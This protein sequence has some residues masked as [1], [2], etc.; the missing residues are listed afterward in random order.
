MISHFTL[1]TLW[2]YSNGKY[3]LSS[4]IA[5]IFSISLNIKHNIN[6]INI[7]TSRWKYYKA[8]WIQFQVLI[9][10]GINRLKTADK[11][12]VLYNVYIIIM[13]YIMYYNMYYIN[14][15]NTLVEKLFGIII[16]AT[17]ETMPRTRN[18]RQKIAKQLHIK[19]VKSC[20]KC[21]HML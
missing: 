21:I 13:Y 3:P 8:D 7:N 12:N 17:T 2:T 14:L 1:L 6:A 5:I 18:K 9:E 4:F 16:E 15:I 19:N 11:T 20:C 10:D